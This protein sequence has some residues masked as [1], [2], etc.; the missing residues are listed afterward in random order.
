MVCRAGRAGGN[1]SRSSC[2]GCARRSPTPRAR[3]RSGAGP[4]VPAIRPTRDAGW[5]A[6][7]KRADRPDQTQLR[8]W[9]DEASYARHVLLTEPTLADQRPYAVELVLMLAHD[10]DTLASV[11]TA[12]QSL[13]RSTPFLQAIGVNLL[14]WRPGP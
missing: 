7:P 2:P 9:I 12:L 11:G 14:P 8:A 4:T 13:A 1:C 6:T 10:P 3:T 5:D